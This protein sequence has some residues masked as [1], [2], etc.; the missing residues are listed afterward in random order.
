MVGADVPD[1]TVT[2]ILDGLVK[3]MDTMAQVGN[4]EFKGMTAKELSRLYGKGKQPPMH[5]A[6]LKYYKA[7]GAIK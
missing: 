4:I 6:A 5:P 2:V 1:E 3:N 7:K